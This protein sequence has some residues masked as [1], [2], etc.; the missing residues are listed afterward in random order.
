ME[1]VVPLARA[2]HLYRIYLASFH[3][4][5]VNAAAR[6]I[7]TSEEFFE[8]MADPRIDKYSIWRDA[9]DPVALAM[10]TNQLEA[11]AWISPEFYAA[12]HPEH[13]AR[14][15][16]YYLGI[17]LV[18][19]GTGQHGL[20]ERLGKE[21]V[22]P[23]VAD[24]GVLAY[25]VCAHNNVNVQFARRVEAILRRVAPVEVSVMDTQTYYQAVFE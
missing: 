14:N 9:D 17:A 12:Q 8:E 21:L 11:V 22:G 25:D 13:A 15:A 16:I 4:L 20:L 1:S 23:C 7:L 18:S 6:Q 2:Q 24:R 5:R 3:H 19:R 10:I